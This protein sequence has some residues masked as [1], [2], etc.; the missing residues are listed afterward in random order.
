MP[1]DKKAMFEIY[2]ILK[3]GGVALITIL[4]DWKRVTTEVFKDLSYNGNY[5]DYGKDVFQLM[6]SIFDSVEIKDIYDFNKNYK[7][8]MGLTKDAD[9]IFICKKLIDV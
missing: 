5:R 8:P 6:E 7:Y 3:G 9:W 4:G 1:E 2:R